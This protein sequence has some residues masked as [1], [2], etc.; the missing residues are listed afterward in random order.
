MLCLRARLRVLRPIILRRQLF[1]WVTDRIKHVQPEPVNYQN[2]SLCL[3]AW[4]S[5]KRCQLGFGDVDGRF[6]PTLLPNVQGHVVAISA[7][8]AHSAAVMN[9]GR[10]YT[11]GWNEVCIIDA[12]LLTR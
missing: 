2:K 8:E 5:G 9:T 3:F 12:A 7:G 6:T 4:G 11:W 1:G 10:L